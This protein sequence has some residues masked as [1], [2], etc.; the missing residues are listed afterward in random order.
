M[1]WMQKLYKYSVHPFLHPFRKRKF[2]CVVAQAGGGEEDIFVNKV[3][4]V[5]WGGNTPTKSRGDPCRC[6][7][8]H[9]SQFSGLDRIIFQTY[10]NL[11]NYIRCLYVLI[12]QTLLSVR[13]QDFICY[14]RE[15]IYLCT[16]R[17][18]TSWFSLVYYSSTCTSVD[19]FLRRSEDSI[20]F[21]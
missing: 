11:K 4:Q 7:C 2:Y 21:A 12:V 17:S 14:K 8:S 20:T 1:S 18:C 10:K 3:V 13:S 5:H 19:I 9:R 16:S 6:F 15:Q